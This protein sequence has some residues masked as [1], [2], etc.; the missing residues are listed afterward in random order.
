MPLRSAG[1]AGGVSVP[2][3]AL[4]PAASV[5]SERLGHGCL[6]DCAITARLPTSISTTAMTRT[7]ARARLWNAFLLAVR[8]CRNSAELSGARSA[9]QPGDGLAGA[10]L[11]I[12]ARFG[13]MSRVSGSTENVCIRLCVP[14]LP[15]PEDPQGG[16]KRT[17]WT[18]YSNAAVV[19]RSDAGSPNA[20]RY[21]LF[22]EQ[23]LRDLVTQGLRQHSII[24]LPWL[25]GWTTIWRSCSTAY[26]RSSPRPGSAAANWRRRRDQASSPTR[27]TCRSGR[28][29]SVRQPALS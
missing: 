29:H 14:L 13:S 7:V 8:I 20:A 15:G 18:A 16:G 12:G 27:S 28:S 9:A 3:P 23:P 6:T 4:R 25:S 24:L 1:C 19:A 11:T 5:C 10:L 22:F 26:R 17:L 2:D 21:Y